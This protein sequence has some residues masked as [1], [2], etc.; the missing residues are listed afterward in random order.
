MCSVAR[1]RQLEI[2]RDMTWPLVH[3]EGLTN[4]VFGII[5]PEA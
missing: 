2:L 4:S 1:A 3:L 5:V